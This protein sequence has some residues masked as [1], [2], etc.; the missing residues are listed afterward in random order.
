[1]ISVSAADLLE[2]LCKCMNK[3]GELKHGKND[4][5]LGSWFAELYKLGKAAKAYLFSSI[6]NH[7]H[8]AAAGWSLCRATFASRS[9][10][11][12]SQLAARTT[13]VNSG[14]EAETPVDGNHDSETP[15]ADTARQRMLDP[16][17]SAFVAVLRSKRQ[18]VY[19]QF[20]RAFKFW[21]LAA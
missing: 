21:G 1:M 2:L 7:R 12:H 15:F 4:Y 10:A 13:A 11:N 17:T 6:F 20:K 3:I 14:A 9:V 19:L 5:G 18:V 16:R 8:D